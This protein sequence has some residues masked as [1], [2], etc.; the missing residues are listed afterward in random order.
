MDDRTQY[1][2]TLIKLVEANQDKTWLPEFLSLREGG[3]LPGGGAG[4]LNDWGPVFSDEIAGVWYTDLYELLRFLFDNDFA[5]SRLGECKKVQFR[6]NIQIIRCLNC[7]KSY[8]HPTRFESNVALNFFRDNLPKFAAERRLPEI[9]NGESSIENRE[10][11]EYRNWLAAQYKLNNIKIYDFVSAEY[12][13]PHCGTAEFETE[14]DLYR[15]E[16]ISPK[17]N[18]FVLQKRNAIWQDF[19]QSP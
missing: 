19:H 6:N 15:I 5:S 17:Q 11:D 1:I 12:I 16:Q 3:H 8:Q 9:L 13:C 18:R 2:E 10:A 4:S 7:G 14:H